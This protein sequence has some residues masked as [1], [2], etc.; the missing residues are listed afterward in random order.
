MIKIDD[1]SKCCGCGGCENI[2]AH[3]AIKMIPDEKGFLYP[4][5]DS[6]KCVN[7]G[8][9]DRVCPIINYCNSNPEPISYLAIRTKDEKILSRS[10]SGGAFGVIANYFISK[11]QGVVY[12]AQ[13]NENMEVVHNGVTSLEGL[14]KFHG[15]KYVQS[16]LDD[17]FSKIR[18]DLK[19]G[20]KVLFSGTPCQVFG[21]KLFLIKKYTNLTTIDVVCNGVPSPMVFRDY[22]TYIQKI[23]G[24]KLL[25]IDMRS[26]KRNWGHYYYYYYSDLSVGEENTSYMTWREFYFTS[27]LNRPSCYN[28]PF[29]NFNRVGDFTIGDFWDTQNKRPEIFSRKGTSLLLISSEKGKRIWGDISDNVLFWSIDKETAAQ[30]RLIEHCNEPSYS[31]RFWTSFFN[32]G[33]IGAYNDC[34]NRKLFYRIRR[35]ILSVYR[36]IFNSK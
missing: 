9:C 8:L 13:Y 16:R 21:L 6:E 10:S 17:T 5:V 7:C 11:L 31:Q 30:P 23:Q 24:S 29:C 26:K 20:K 36:Q 12:G 27:F 15:S 35:R 28:C 1:K 4:Q 18:E 19:Q 22:V 14:E 32:K 25:S 2:C 34:I 3:S 33:L